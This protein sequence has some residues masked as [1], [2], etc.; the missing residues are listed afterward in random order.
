M[1]L[2]V[3]LCGILAILKNKK[4]A[5]ILFH[6]KSGIVVISIYVR[7]LFYFKIEKNKK[8]TQGQTKYFD[9]KENV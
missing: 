7:T 6:C 5:W 8:E 4:K 1:C 2:I 9:S 3:P